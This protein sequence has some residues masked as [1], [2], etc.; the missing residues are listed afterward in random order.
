MDQLVAAL[1]PMFTSLLPSAGGGLFSAPLVDE[2][3]TDLAL[4]AKKKSFV[5]YRFRRPMELIVPIHPVTIM[6]CEV[7]LCNIAYWKQPV[8]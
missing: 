6:S 5:N 7:L 1:L 4:S 8:S 2:I 3:A